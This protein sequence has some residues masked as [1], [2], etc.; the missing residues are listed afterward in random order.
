V[1]WPSV[2][3]RLWSAH[4]LL[5]VVATAAASDVA[6]AGRA[7][8]D[9]AADPAAPLAG[10]TA[11]PTVG[12]PW[13]RP[14]HVHLVDADGAA[15]AQALAHALGCWH[16]REPGAPAL[17]RMTSS[18]RPPAGPA[19]TRIHPSD[20]PGRDDRALVTALL[21][22]WI[23]P[24]CGVDLRVI[25]GTWAATL[26]D[27]GHAELVEVLAILGGATPALPQR[28]RPA[29]PTPTTALPPAATWADQAAAMAA[30]WRLSISLGPGLDPTSP[31]PAVDAHWL[32]AP[33]EGVQVGWFHRVLCLDRESPHDRQHPLERRRFAVVPVGHLAAG[34]ADG[35]ALCAAAQATLGDAGHAV[36]LPYRPA[37]LLAA[38]TDAI[39]RVLASIDR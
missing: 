21:D 7:P 16:I 3:A 25:D 5:C 8:R 34:P 18:L 29:W 23:G 2:S 9:W 36:L 30:T 26:P 33:T 15:R 37:L 13:S 38:D 39:H 20:L 17:V 22:P 4:V 10:I 27:P 11:D 19:V 14:V 1:R 24:G 31:A 28:L 32:L 12:M 6:S 35:A